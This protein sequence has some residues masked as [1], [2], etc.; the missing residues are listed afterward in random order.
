M[1]RVIEKTVYQF[2]ELDDSAK[3]RARD[4][5]RTLGVESDE[6]TDYEH[7]TEAASILGITF[8]T[9]RGSSD[10]KIWWSGFSSQGDGASFEGRY[11]YAKGAAKRI[12]EFAPE[13]KEL[14]R[15]ADALQALQRRHFYQLWAVM[16][17]GHLSN[18]YSHSGTMSVDVDR[19]GA[20]MDLHDACDDLRQLMRDFADWIYSQL[21]SSNDYLTSDERIDEAIRINECEF[22]EEGNRA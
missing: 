6:L 2:D 19:A 13:D 17:R 7:W 22:T 16:G 11:E 18:H 9:Q 8:D 21:N 5:Y 3:E 14:H 4:W 10:P 1:P 15:I 12:R 20:D